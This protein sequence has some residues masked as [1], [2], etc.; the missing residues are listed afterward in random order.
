MGSSSVDTVLICHGKMRGCRHTSDRP[1]GQATALARNSNF[2]LAIRERNDV[3]PL[4][5]NPNQAA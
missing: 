2:S 1:D 3:E 5:Q 4:A